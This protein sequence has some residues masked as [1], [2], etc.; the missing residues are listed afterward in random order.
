MDTRKR[1]ARFAMLAG[2]CLLCGCATSPV[3]PTV[4]SYPSPNPD[5]M[6]PAPAPGQFR[7]DLEAILAKGQ[8]PTSG[9][10]SPSSPIA[11]T[12]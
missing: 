12:D 4:E 8:G 5:L 2:L 9:P 1:F 7:R 10:T 3:C 11:P 6:E